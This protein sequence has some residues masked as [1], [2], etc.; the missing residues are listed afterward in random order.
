V[1]R[2]VAAA[3]LLTLI[4]LVALLGMQAAGGFRAYLC[5]C[6]GEV[7][8]TNVDHCH[9]PHSA[10]CHDF[11]SGVLQRHDEDSGDRR[12]HEQVIQELW[13]RSVE[14][15]QLPAVVPVLLAWLPDVFESRVVMGVATVCRS[16]DVPDA[17]PPTGVTVA[18]TVVF[19]I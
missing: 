1:N 5:N 2:R 8:W 15:F 16:I 11:E 19:I 7:R 6:G 17:I 14:N 9:G 12:D 18:R 10:T 13:L 3:R 4:C